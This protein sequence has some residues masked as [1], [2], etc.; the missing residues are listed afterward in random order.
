MT[1][2]TPGGRQCTLR[3]L[4][5]DISAN[6]ELAAISITGLTTD[7][8]DVVVGDLFL[9]CRSAAGDGRE[10]IGHALVAGALVVAVD[11]VPG[12]ELQSGL[13][14][15][16]SK[17]GA[18]IFAVP[19][20][21]EQ[22]G[23]IAAHF[24]GDPSLFMRVIGVTGTN[25]KT[26]CSQFI[27]QCL[28]NAEEPCAVIGTLGSGL[29]GSLTP[30]GFTT[31][32]AV[33][34]QRSLAE[35]RA[36]GARFVSMEVSSHGLAQGRTDATRIEV[37]LLTNLSRDHLDYHGDMEAYAGA[38]RKL[39]QLPGLRVAVLNLD[40]EFGQRVANEIPVGVARIGYS[41]AQHPAAAD[42]PVIHA[43]ALPR[44]TAGLRLQ[45]FSPWGDG[46]LQSDLLGGFNAENLL[47]VLGGLLALDIPFATALEKLAKVQPPPGRMERFG[48]VFGQPLV[49]VD[50]AHTPDA[51]EHVL[52]TLRE[53]CRGKLWA[54]FGCGGDRDR[55][56]RPQMGA[57]VER[58]A[59]HVVLTDDNPRSESARDI[60]KDILAGMA[61]PA[62]VVV[63]HDRQLAI[64]YAV[65][66]AS[67][68]DIVL[69]A[70]KGHEDYQI[71]GNQRRL[72]SDR[73]VVRELLDKVA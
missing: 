47:A 41:M 14:D 37:A 66:A 2:F 7:S 5:A 30:T 9:A 17:Y 49:V 34:L 38:K 54:V 29:W 21:A 35:F 40:D 45:I 18:T 1:H 70:G 44:E 43:R 71:I 56:K 50:Y 51:L 48:G 13:R 20:L 28:H 64:A 27:A 19:G 46:E 33:A 62:A 11:V 3:E 53:Y 61:N 60:T 58:L 63:Q 16:A 52:G 10:F 4:F 67:A 59:D 25:G 55:G 73:V 36:A 57:I 26:S 12:E 42:F 8:R 22:I 39:F 68:D 32:L 6:A 23:R 69:V 72:F 65:A 31:P 15:L 24:Y